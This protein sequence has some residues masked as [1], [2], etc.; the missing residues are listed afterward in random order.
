MRDG[1]LPT[2]FLALLVTACDSGPSPLTEA[3]SSGLTEAER[4]ALTLEVEETLGR[5]T[6]AMNAHDSERV[7]AFFRNSDD[8]LYLGC[9]GFMFGWDTFSRRVGRYYARSEDVTFQQEIVRTQV[10]SPTVAV[11]A[12]RGSST[13]AEAE[14]LFLTEV[15]VREEDGRWLIA[16]EHESW[17]GCSPPSDPH[18]FTSEMPGMGEMGEMGDTAATSESGTERE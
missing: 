7:M 9:T 11:V 2:L 18:P 12:L 5:L 13:E 16:H 1:L 10:L 3:A 15:L 4:N 8:F 6:E 14:A 17:P